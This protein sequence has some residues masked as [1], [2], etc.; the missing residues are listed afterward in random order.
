MKTYIRFM[1]SAMV[2]VTTVWGAQNP[3]EGRGSY[4]ERR[5]GV[6]S[7]NRVRTTFFNYGLIGR[8]S[9][10]EDYG[11]EWPIN[12]GH[13]YIGDVS[14]MVGAEVPITV[15]VIDTI[16]GNDTLYRDSIVYIHSVEVADGPRGNN[17][18]S[19]DG[20]TFWGWEPIPG[21]A[22]PDT[23]LIAMSHIPESWPPFWPD[24]MDHPDDP[25]WPGAWNGYF[26]KNVMNADQESYYVMD[27]NSDEEFPFYPDSADST[28]RGLGLRVGV[29]GFQWSHPLAQDCI[30]WHFDI[31]N[32]GTSVL[33][34]VVFG[35]IWGGIV[36]GDGDSHDDMAD[37]IREDR[38]VYCYDY[39][40][41][42]NTGWTPVGYAGSAF[43]ETPGDPWNGID[44]DNDG[45]YGPGPTLQIQD[46]QP[47]VYS[48]GDDI[49]LID[50][51]TFERTVTTM[52]DTGVLIRFRTDTIRI[53]PGD[54]V[55]EDPHNRF[56][57]NLNGLIDE[58]INL[59]LGYKYIDW[60][61]G[62]GLDN[63][64]IDERRDDGIDNDGD[65]DP[66]TDDVGADGLPGTGDYGE[67]DGIPTAGE[68]DF[69]ATDK[70][71]SDQIGLTSFYFFHPFN[72]VKLRNDE[73]LWECLQPG[74]FSTIELPP[75]GAD[76]DFIWGSG[77]FSL[78]PGQTE[79]FS[80]AL[81]FGENREAIVRTT[82]IVQQIYNWNYRFA[83]APEL[84]TVKAVAGDRKVILYWD[85]RA[86]HSYD[87]MTGYD[88]EGYKI[89]KATWPT[90][91]DAGEITDGF[92]NVIFNV[93]IA[94]Y[95]LID[96]DSGFFPIAINGVQFYLGDNT[97]LRHCFVD[98]NVENGFTY[99]YAVTA[100]DKGSV[101]LGITPSETP[102]FATID[103]TGEIHTAIN[104][105]AVTPTAPAAGYVPPSL[106]EFNH[107][108]GFATGE[109]AVEI[110]DPREVRDGHTYEVTFKDSAFSTKSFTWV[111]VTD[112]DNPDTL[113]KD[114]P[115]VKPWQ[116][117]DIRHGLRLYLDNDEYIEVIDTLTGWNDTSLLPVKSITT[118]VTPAYAGKRYP[119]D[120]IIVFSESVLDT[121]TE[122]STSW[123]YPLHLPAVPVNFTVI[124]CN[125]GDRIEFAFHEKGRPDS[126]LSPNERLIF[127]QQIPPDTVLTPTWVVEFASDTTAVLPTAGDTF[128]IYMRKPFLS[129]DVYRFTVKGAYVDTNKAKY[130]LSRVKVV[131]NPYIAVAM[132]E[133]HN[134]Y[135]SGRGPREIHFIHLP[136]KCTIRIYNLRGEL[137]RK[138]EHE[139]PLDDGTCKWDLLTKDNLEVS[140]GVY[141]YHIEAPGIGEKIG[142]FAIIK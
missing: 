130:D 77:Y 126:S 105:V 136:A 75:G 80:I 102:K 63:P 132:W 40:G 52:P 128:Y 87:P 44:D 90:W 69:D 64:L 141:I 129:N 53:M 89:Y 107:I 36:G 91:E 135:T 25:G 57:D 95:D 106:E 83:K 31:T 26:G 121:S 131:P 49:V 97:G 22:N 10:A 76:G 119:A 117:R 33:H 138:I 72:K 104:V 108:S 39:D 114:C 29:R 47:K 78:K 5:K 103:P 11:G 46:F 6:H 88:F 20:T 12:S 42:G 120:Y 116:E 8:I 34:K 142:K 61:T 35:M 82:H 60:L 32:V 73:Q 41:I 58:N 14:I 94:Q 56:D 62:E 13:E 15:R 134:P 93:P 55:E 92:G 1:L 67:G 113:V 98:T 17:E 79:R 137:I 133:P 140:Y 43:L 101:E 2:L 24:R 99:F 37:F 50:Y 4:Y 65:W 71:E 115:E 30:F 38:V 100:Y 54:T 45:Q 84:P 124:N 23:D 7:G 122:F 112:P 21:Y 28:R 59:H 19:P 118:L 66:L 85:D 18:Y 68:P 127:L 27:D 86:E 51:N 139:A 109:V 9:P 48:V 123:P 125:T 70:D 111:D 16:I 110:I 3:Y 74:Y 81:L 96:A